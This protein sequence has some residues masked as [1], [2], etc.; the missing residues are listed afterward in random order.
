VLDKP[1]RKWV[2]DEYAS[3]DAA[4]FLAAANGPK[5]GTTFT[6]S[7]YG[8]QDVKPVVVGV[9]ERL[10]ATS[11]LV[12]LAS[13][14]TDGFNLDDR[15]S[16]WGSR[17]H[18]QRRLGWPDPVRDDGHHRRTQLVPPERQLRRPGLLVPDRPAGSPRLDPVVRHE[19]TGPG[20]FLLGSGVA[21]RPRPLAF[22]YLAVGAEW[23]TSLRDPVPQAV[24]RITC[25]RCGGES[26]HARETR[27]SGAWTFESVAPSPYLGQGLT[28]GLPRGGRLVGGVSA[29][30]TVGLRPCS[31][32]RSV[33][34]VQP[35]LSGTL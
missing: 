17:R 14:L 20:R 32:T 6:V 28:L 12:N 27:S 8:L 1:V 15:E 3:L 33:D 24:A 35:Q 16:W 9:R 13:A 34:P 5:K 25:D 7:G 10:M 2:V 30:S 31:P 4:G 26:C 18:V 19:G 22:L 29:A 21:L 23:R 11:Q